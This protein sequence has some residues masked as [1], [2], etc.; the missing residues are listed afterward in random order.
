[1]GRHKDEDFACP[2]MWQSFGLPRSRASRPAPPEIRGPD[3]ARWSR[4]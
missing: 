4:L 3:R 2:P 1:V